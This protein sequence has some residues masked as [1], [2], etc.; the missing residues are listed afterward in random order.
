MTMEF[1]KP[2]PVLVGLGFRHEIRSVMEA[3]RV[4]ND[5][6]SETREKDAA[7]AACRTALTARTSADTARLAFI[8]FCLK[9]DLLVEDTSIKSLSSRSH[10]GL[11]SAERR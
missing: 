7:L 3:L 11:P 4:L 2:V 8:V 6:P 9:Q 5:C 10:K 1:S